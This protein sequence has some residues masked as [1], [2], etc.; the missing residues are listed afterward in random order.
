M[1][2]EINGVSGATSAAPLAN[3]KCSLDSEEIAGEHS[4]A[5]F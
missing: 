3:T 5:I 1:S 2:H 4:S